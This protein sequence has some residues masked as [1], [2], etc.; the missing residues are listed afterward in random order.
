MISVQLYTIY[1]NRIVNVGGLWQLNFS[2][3][4]EYWLVVLQA[5]TFLATDK[6]KMASFTS[7]E[8]T[9]LPDFSLLTLYRRT[10]L[11]MD[12]VSFFV[13]KVVT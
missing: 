8:S 12:V 5:V 3:V 1:Q 6:S 9:L 4:L 10:I 2:F 11:G 13:K 7:S